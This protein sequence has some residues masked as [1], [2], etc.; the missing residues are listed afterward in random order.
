MRPA[1]TTVP[2]RSHTAPLEETLG[3]LR[4]VYG[5]TRAS[6]GLP[7]GERW[8]HLDALMDTGLDQAFD[9]LETE[10]ESAG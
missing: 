10:A 9:Q 1:A 7:A 3:R 2:T 4:E 5:A 8:V 6:V